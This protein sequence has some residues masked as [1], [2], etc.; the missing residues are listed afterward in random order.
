MFC[1]SFDF[2][3]AES[4]D[5][6]LHG[7]DLT[8]RFRKVSHLAAVMFTS[9]LKISIALGLALGVVSRSYDFKR[10]L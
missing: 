6:N 1:T 10:P 2:L 7:R 5:S 3:D 8:T 9:L 4:A